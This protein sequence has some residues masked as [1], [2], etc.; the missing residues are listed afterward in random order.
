MKWFLIDT[1]CK[2]LFGEPLYRLSFVVEQARDDIGEYISVSVFSS[3]KG[4]TFSF[5]ADS[6]SRDVYMIL[7]ARGLS[8][9]KVAKRGTTYS[10]YRKK[11]RKKA[12]KL[13]RF[14]LFKKK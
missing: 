14:R 7:N 13:L 11:K 10:E 4:T 2:R 6:V 8:Y 1:V 9:G 3:K 5:D 12:N